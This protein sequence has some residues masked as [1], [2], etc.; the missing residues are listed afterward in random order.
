LGVSGRYKTPFVEMGFFDHSYR[1]FHQKSKENWGAFKTLIENHGELR[2][3]FQQAK[4]H[5][6]ELVND[7]YSK[8]QVPPQRQF[9]DIPVA[10]RDAYRKAFA[11]Q[12]K[13]GAETKAFWLDVTGLNE[14]AAGALLET[15]EAYYS[16]AT[17]EKLAP[18]EVFGRAEERCEPPGERR[19]IQHIQIVEPLLA[20][21]D[22]LFRLARH[23][24]VQSVSDVRGYWEDLGR[25]DHTLQDA[26]GR[27]W[28]ASD[29]LPTLQGTAR[30]RL[31]KLLNVATN[32]SLEEQLK[33]LLKYHS[34][35]MKERGQFRW[36]EAVHDVEIRVHGRT[37]PLPKAEKRPIGAW[38]NS[39]YVHQFYNLVA[40]YQGGTQ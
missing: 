26:A 14:G 40:G 15:L 3:C 34:Q 30:R 37:E 4:K 27:I 17:N 1:Y 38:V 5:L 39:Y 10:L 12:G 25:T 11:T 7:S 28:D 21:L 35:V 9:R 2:D 31:Q 36:V 23:K 22:L 19:K 6:I 32:E 33:G 20:E 29:L 13:V 8:S 24:K 16:T 18:K